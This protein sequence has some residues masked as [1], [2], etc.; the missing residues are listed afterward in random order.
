MLLHHYCDFS[1]EYVCCSV[2]TYK[3]Q[4]EAVLVFYD[5][6]TDCQLQDRTCICNVWT[7]FWAR[8]PGP[9]WHHSSGFL[10]A[11]LDTLP[12]VPER[13][14]SSSLCHVS[15]S[16]WWQWCACFSDYLPKVDV[17]YKRIRVQQETT[18]TEL[19]QLAVRKFGIKVILSGGVSRH[20]SCL[21][22]WFFMSRSWWLSL[23]TC[24]SCL[25]S[26]FEFLCLIMSHTLWLCLEYVSVR[27]N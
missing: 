25:G 12:I 13:W 4:V 18:T 8:Y 1:S 17:T 22:T 6:N 27:H 3:L 11:L 21:E 9:P 10:C 26:C 16:Y 23:H 15:Q 24:M 20:V 19:I 2:K 5:Y 14:R 7:R